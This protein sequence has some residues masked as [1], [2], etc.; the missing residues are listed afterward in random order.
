M[1]GLFDLYPRQT[2]MIAAEPTVE[3][4]DITHW[5]QDKAAREAR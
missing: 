3:I 5:Q 1:P 4:P 2:L